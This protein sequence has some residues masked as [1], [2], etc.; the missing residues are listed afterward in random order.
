MEDRYQIN[1][2]GGV[3]PGSVASFDKLA[4]R[5]TGLNGLLSGLGKT[6]V[7]TFIGTCLIGLSANATEAAD[8]LNKLASK[9][10]E[11][12]DESRNLPASQTSLG[13]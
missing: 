12:V 8:P 9:A 11:T 7:A 4:G 6:L 10:G 3:S 1:I 13:M 2:G 5:A